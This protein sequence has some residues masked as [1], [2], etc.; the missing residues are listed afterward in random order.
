MLF[1]HVALFKTFG[2]E[3]SPTHSEQPKVNVNTTAQYN[4][5]PQRHIYSNLELGRAESAVYYV[6]VN[7]IQARWRT[8]RGGLLLLSQNTSKDTRTVPTVLLHNDFWVYCTTFATSKRSKK[9]SPHMYFKGLMNL[10]NL[11]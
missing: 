9:D 3:Y 8:E 1:C 7:S 10:N 4:G 11:S 6:T 2:C 5:G